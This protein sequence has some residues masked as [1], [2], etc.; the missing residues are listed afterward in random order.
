MLPTLA[1]TATEI[2][3]FKSD[4][5]LQANLR[6]SFV[7]ILGFLGLVLDGNGTVA[8]GGNFAARSPDVWDAPNHNW[9]RISRILRCLTLLGLNVLAR[10][11]FDRL[12]AFYESKRFPIPTDTFRYWTNA[13]RE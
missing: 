1:L 13:V 6:K 11:F 3:T 2:A 8:E 4:P 9:L 10:A 12:N 5:L 7:R